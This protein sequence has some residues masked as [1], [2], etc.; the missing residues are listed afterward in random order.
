MNAMLRSGGQLYL[1]DVIFEEADATAS[2]SRWID[3]LGGIGG[4]KLREEIALHVREEYSTYDWI[5]EG[6]LQR[7]GFRIQSKN[8]VWGV[9]GTVVCVKE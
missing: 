3:E 6:L 4:A 8:M 1:K 5:L 7:A 9:V 2:I